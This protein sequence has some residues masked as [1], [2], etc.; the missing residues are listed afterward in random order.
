MS[1]IP[2]AVLSDTHDNVR[3]IAE[4]CDIANHR[5][6]RYLFH[7]G[8]IISPL[9]AQ[10]LIEFEG[11]VKAVYGNCDSNRTE[12][13]RV[14]NTFGGEIEQSPSKFEIEGKRI[15]LMH[16]PV[17]LDDL[18][19]AQDTDYIM[20]GHLHKIDVRQEGRTFILNPGESGGWM[21]K[22]TFFIVD[23]NSGKYELFNL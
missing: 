2:V 9:T 23:L 18:I 20:Y 17:E 14:F 16:E 13:S 19:K 4:I 1:G 21:H 15:V 22:P 12:L 8:D 3:N 10:N 5:Q 11:I 7:L 6:C